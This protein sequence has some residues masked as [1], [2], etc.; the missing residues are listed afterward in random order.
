MKNARFWY[1]VVA[2]SLVS[3]GAWAA[4]PP[5]PLFSI[6]V[7]GRIGYAN[8]NGKIAIAPQFDEAGEFAGG[9]AWIRMARRY[10]YVDMQ[11][12]IT[13]NPQY[14]NARDFSEGLACVELERWGFVGA[15]GQFAINPQLDRCSDFQGATRRPLGAS[16]LLNRAGMPSI[17]NDEVGD[18]AGGYARIYDGER[19][20]YID[21]TG[22]IV[23]NPQFDRAGDFRNA[24]APVR[25]GD[26]WGY[27]DALGKYRI[28]PQFNDAWAF[29]EGLARVDVDGR[30]GFVDIN[31]KMAIN[32]QF[33]RAGDFH[34]GLAFVQVSRRGPYGFVN[35]SGRLAINPQFDEAWT[36]SNGLARSS[37]R[38]DRVCERRGKPSTTRPSR[39]RARNAAAGVPVRT[40]LI[41]IAASLPPNASDVEMPQ[42]T[43]WR[44]DVLATT[45]IWQSGSVSRW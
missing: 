5:A 40:C 34:Q 22:K 21:G 37:S 26:K 43:G 42:W 14:N 18:F 39:R 33:D 11:G 41:T 15:T 16:G 28:N 45:S 6:H 23:I 30:I 2:L 35:A 32:P 3:L 9:Y 31:G 7:G 12:R 13:I 44:R 24:R 10:G 8:L 20:G 36:S 27:I 25:I 38:R 4:A 19:W 29:S 17:P 1:V